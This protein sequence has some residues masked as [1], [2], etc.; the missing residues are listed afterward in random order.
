[1]ATIT[2]VVLSGAVKAV[3]GSGTIAEMRAQQGA[4][5]EYWCKGYLSRGDG[6]E[7]GGSVRPS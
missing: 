3:G 6:R 2:I 4:G 1:V 5:E 7:R